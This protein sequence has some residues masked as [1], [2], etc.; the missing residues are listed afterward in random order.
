[1]RRP[2]TFGAAFLAALFLTVSPRA[3]PLGPH[4]GAAPRAQDV[5]FEVLAPEEKAIIDRIA[6]DFFEKDLRPAQTRAIEDATAARYRRAS[7]KER[8]AIRA[9]RRAAWRAMPEARRAAL[10]NAAEPR[11]DNLSPDQRAPFRRHAINRLSGAGAI[12]ADA[13]ADALDDDI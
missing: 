3:E 12:D 13:L 1:V 11:Y 8:A 7:S 9:E 2:A 4:D 5:R 6:A 10:M